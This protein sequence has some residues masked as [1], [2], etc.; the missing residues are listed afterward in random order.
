MMTI[1]GPAGVPQ[2]RTQATRRADPDPVVGAHR[3]PDLAR[4]KRRKL[5]SKT[6]SSGSWIERSRHH[7]EGPR[8]CPD[9]R[10]LGFR[11]LGWSSVFSGDERWHCHANGCF[12]HAAGGHY[13][14]PDRV[15]CIRKRCCWPT[16]P[17]HIST[18]LAATSGRHS[19]PSRGSALPVNC[20]K[21]TTRIMHIVAWLL[22]QRVINPA[23]SRAREGRR[24]E[25]RL[26]HAQDSD[27]DDI[28]VLPP[29]EAADQFQCRPLRARQKARRWRI[30]SGGAAKPRARADGPSGAGTRRPQRLTRPPMRPF[31][32]NPGPR[33]W[34]VRTRRG[35]S[36]E[37][38]PP[39]PC[40]RAA[41]AARGRLGT[42][43]RLI[44][45]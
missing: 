7:P 13:V 16:K 22:T 23:K 2:G 9:R 32:F 24:P 43:R 17:A 29:R 39:G 36:A 6:R 35:A 19:S 5:I 25:R 30:G 8:N 33:R 34:P 20:S 11:T 45:R 10:H 26:G 4:L 21:V 1:R 42:G 18:R 28:N 27:P 15:L 44:A 3:R 38:L 31:T 37:K 41:D 40:R 12:G 14:A